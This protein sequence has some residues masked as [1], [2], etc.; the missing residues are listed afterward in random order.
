MRLAH[1]AGPDIPTLVRELDHQLGDTSLFTLAFLYVT[2]ALADRLPLLLAELK[3]TT[4]IPH[5]TGSVGMALNLTGEEIY[6][7]PAVAI[8]ATEIPED[9]F[10]ILPLIKAHPETPLEPLQTWLMSQNHV[11]G[12]LHGDPGNPLTPDLVEELPRW[13]PPATLV[14]G[15]TSS[16]SELWQI[17]DQPLSG[18]ISGVLFSDQCCIRTAHTQGCE[19]IGTSHTIT[20][21]ERNII[22]ELDERPALEVLKEDIGEILSRNL[23]KIA[24]Y[25]FAALPIKESQDNDY[26]VRNII[27]LD[28]SQQL[29]AI[30]ERIEEGDALLFTRRDSNSAQSDLIRMLEDLKKELPGPAKGGI[31]FSCLGRGRYMFGEESAEMGLIQEHLGDIPIVG[32][33]ANGEIYQHNLYGFTGVLTIFC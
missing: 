28:E 18:G 9:D 14:G 26:M 19:P 11:L 22:I 1:S 4:G 16:Q 13:L 2:D 25:I 21:C 20:R 15:I 10:R 32:F 29:I 17:A 33:Q 31:Y 12:I 5:W 8:L 30:G 24:G 27:G 6:D 3:L 7:R 23:S